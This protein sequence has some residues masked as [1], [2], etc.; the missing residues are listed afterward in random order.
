MGA[1]VSQNVWSIFRA[2]HRPAPGSTVQDASEVSVF[3]S[4]PSVKPPKEEKMITPP[5]PAPSNEAQLPPVTLPETFRLPDLLSIINSVF[6]YG[7]NEAQ[8]AVMEAVEQWYR[9]YRVRLNA[10]NPVQFIP[11]SSY[12][13]YSDSFMTNF[14][15]KGNFDRFCAL[16]HVH[17]DYDHFET[18]LMFYLWAFM[19]NTINSVYPCTT[20]S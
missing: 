2:T 15:E 10:Y 19:V 1:V 17:A 12:K 14:L 4:N 11:P 7:V 20:F 16:I 5:N 6:H 13:P 18:A 9:R 3:V 8:A